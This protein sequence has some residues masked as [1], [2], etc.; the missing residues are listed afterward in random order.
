MLLG[1]GSV[2]TTKQRLKATPVKPVGS[3]GRSSGWQRCCYRMGFGALVAEARQ[4]VSHK[5]YGK[6]SCCI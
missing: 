6:R 3:A 5:R 2:T 4:L 1:V